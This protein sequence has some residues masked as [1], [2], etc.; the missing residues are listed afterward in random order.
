R[1]KRQI[2]EID[3]LE[4]RAIENGKVVAMMIIDV[5]PEE[6]HTGYPMLYTMLSFSTVKGALTQGYKWL[7]SVAKMMGFRFVLTT[8]QTGP[9]EITNR[10]K[11]LC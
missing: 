9:R 8:R 11:E 2:E 1:L 4:Y 6:T 7:Y 5:L 3:R 10:I